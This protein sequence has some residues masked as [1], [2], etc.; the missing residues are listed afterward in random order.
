MRRPLLGLGLLLAAAAGLGAACAPAPSPAPPAAAPAPAAPAIPPPAPAAPVIPEASAA[1]TAQLYEAAKKEGKVLLYTTG[2]TREADD[3]KKPFEAKYPGVEV[4][5]FTGTSEEIVNRFMAEARA[6]KTL[7]D[8]IVM[9]LGGG[10]TSL[11][12]EGQIGK[13]L[14]PELKNYPSDGFHPEG[15]YAYENYSVYVIAYNT[16]LVSE[17]EAPKSY[18]DL[19]KPQWKGK[20]GVEQAPVEWFVNMQKWMGREKAVE[21][22]KQLAPLAQLRSGHTT[23]Y[24]LVQAGEFVAS[25]TIYQHRA[26]QGMEQGAPVKWVAPNPTFVFPRAA[27][28]T[29]SAP[30]PNA[31]QLFMDWRLSEE[32][33]QVVVKQKRVPTRNGVFPEPPSLKEGVNFFPADVSVYEALEKEEKVLRDIFGVF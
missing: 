6:G 26:Q 29:K 3:Y 17:A 22:F 24:E 19:L 2:T 27:G 5:Y 32:G 33:Q 12:K 11:L 23:V 7:G 20:I 25:P 18:T 1:R 10:W 15:L 31:A 28:I 4:E 14:S 9:T 8:M 30:H 16:T 21:F 13:Y